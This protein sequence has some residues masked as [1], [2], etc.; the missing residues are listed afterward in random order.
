MSFGDTWYS[1]SEIPISLYK[2][3]RIRT[4]LLPCQ[5]KYN[6]ISSNDSTYGAIVASFKFIR[7]LD[8]HNMGIKTIP[9]SIKKLKHLRYLDL[10]KNEDI[11]ML[12]NSIVKLY[13]LQTLKLSECRNL[14]ELLRDINKLVNLR[15][16][17]IDE[18]SSLTHMPN[19]LGQLTNLQTLSRFVISKGSIDSIPKSSSGLKELA[20][21]NEL[22]DNLS[23][24]NLKHRKDAVLEYKDAN[25]KEKHRL[26]RLD[27][28]WVYEA[29]D[30][31][32]AGYDDM[33]LI[34]AL[35]PHI[36]LKALSLEQ[37][38]GVI[39]PHWLVSLTNLVQFKLY[40]CNKCQ[41]I[42]PLDQIPS[43]KII[44]LICLNSLE[45][46]FFRK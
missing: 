37:Y 27:L 46:V 17:E 16:L 44:Y 40:S 13:N 42:P 20:K 10:S 3:R 11:K 36:N 32:G 43:L 5:P 31:T 38:G 19:G 7:L 22:R 2:A 28:N 12:P 45:Q 15:F 14:K 25:L 23:I 18:Y 35:Q 26:D 39:F 9:S 24:E 29:I 6:T 8:L 21:L 4:F 33:L 30:E 1:S 41:Y 34:E